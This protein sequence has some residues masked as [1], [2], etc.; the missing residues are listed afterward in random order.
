MPR[1]VRDLWQ[2]HVSKEWTPAVPGGESG[3]PSQSQI[4]EFLRDWIRESQEKG[5]VLKIVAT[6]AGTFCAHGQCTRELECQQKW[7]WSQTGDVITWFVQGDHAPAGDRVAQMGHADRLAH[8]P[9]LQARAQ[10]MSEQVNAEQ[11]PTLKDLDKARRRLLRRKAPAPT[12]DVADAWVQVLQRY[13]AANPERKPHEML[14]YNLICQADWLPLDLDTKA[15]Q[16]SCL[17]LSKNMVGIA[18]KVLE[19]GHRAQHKVTLLLDAT[20]KLCV[21]DWALVI[22]GVANKH[23]GQKDHLPCTECVPLGYGWVPKEN[24]DSLAPFL[25]TLCEIYVQHNVPLR[26]KLAAAMVD[27]HKG[28]ESALRQ[29]RKFT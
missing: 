17:F 22:A 21:N 18:Q 1:A 4:R 10:M 5:K 20:Y 12:P 6:P 19:E 24:F 7:K 11:A 13:I 28:G 14:Y 26:T 8:L 9:P 2:Q 16:G 27:G 25:V 23:L 3:P 15:T 29:A